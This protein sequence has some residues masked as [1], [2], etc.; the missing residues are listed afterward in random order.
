MGLQVAELASDL[1]RYEQTI[2][3]KVGGLREGVLG[4][5]STPDAAPRTRDR[6]GDEG[7][8]GPGPD[9]DAGAG[10]ARAAEAAAGRGPPARSHAARARAALRRAD[11]APARDA[12]H[13]LRGAD[14]HPAPARGSARPHDP[15]VRVERP[16]PHHRRHGRRGAP[17][18]PLLP[19]PARAQRRLRGL[20]LGRAVDHRR[21]EPGA[22]GH[23]QRR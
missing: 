17:A 3:D 13:H 23:P 18:L 19:H 4:R 9:A 14:L 1:P 20:D 11:P 5:L 6:A 21:A 15:A 7:R 2:R 10:R 22:V 8:S 16:A 12:R